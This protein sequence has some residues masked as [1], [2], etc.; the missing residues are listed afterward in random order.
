[1][2][3]AR[4]FQAGQRAAERDLA[5]GERHAGDAELGGR[6]FGLSSRRLRRRGRLG[7]GTSGE[8]KAAERGRSELEEL[9]ARD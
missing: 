7:R 5:V 3:I 9:A 8:G 6:A 2:R 4:R 1:M